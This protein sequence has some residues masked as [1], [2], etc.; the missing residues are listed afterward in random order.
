MA[1]REK[2]GT[3]EHAVAYAVGVDIVLIRR[4]DEANFAAWDKLFTPAEQ[5][6]ATAQARPAESYAGIFAAKEA[7]IKTLPS[8]WAGNIRDIELAHEADG[9]PFLSFY[10]AVAEKIATLNAH[11]DIS[12]AHDGDYAIAYAARRPEELEES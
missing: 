5:A 8:P 4:F 6:Y 10:G 1:A 3:A 11:I 9:R 7:C 12:V 2:E